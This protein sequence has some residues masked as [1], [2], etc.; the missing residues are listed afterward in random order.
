MPQTATV[1]LESSTGE[2]QVTP[3][4]DE[5]RTTLTLVAASLLAKGDYTLTVTN[6]ESSQTATASVKDR[7]ITSIVLKG[8]TAYTSEDNTKAYIYYDVLDQYNDT[9][10]TS[11][12]INW[13]I[14]GAASNQVNTST[15]KI[16][17]Q[18]S[19]DGKETF[20]Y[21]SKISVTGVE[22]VSGKS[23]SEVIEIGMA[24]A[25]D[26]IEMV[27]FVNDKG[28]KTKIVTSLP[29]DFAK[30]T[31]YLLYKTKD[32]GGNE[33]DAE[34]YDSQKITF[35]VEQPLLVDSGAFEAGRLYTIDGT[36]YASVKVNPG[37]YAERGGDVTF[38][39][40]SNKTGK[41]TPK[42]FAVGE[43][44]LLSSL[45]LMAPSGIIADGDE[46]GIP[47]KALATDG[48]EIKNYE[49]IVRSTNKLNINASEGILEIFQNDDG[50][51]GIKWSDDDKYKA[52]A[53]ENCYSQSGIANSMTR[54]ITLTTIVA[55]GTNVTPLTLTVHDMRRPDS[56]KEVDETRSGL[57]NTAVSGFTLGSA[58]GYA[59]WGVRYYDQYNQVL[60][61]N[62]VKKFFEQAETDKGVAGKN[63]GV[64]IERGSDA[65]DVVGYWNEGIDQSKVVLTNSKAYSIS[66][67]GTESEIEKGGSIDSYYPGTVNAKEKTQFTTKY[68]IVSKTAGSDESKWAT[69]SKVIS[70]TYTVVPLSYM[71]SFEI[72]DT[73]ERYQLITVN[74]GKT[75]GSSIK[76]LSVPVTGATIGDNGEFVES[77]ELK[78]SGLT[79]FKVKGTTKDNV[80]V[81]IPE[82]YVEYVDSDLASANKYAASD[83]ITK[84]YNITAVSA[85]AI[86]WNELYDEDT[87]KATRKPEALKTLR[88]LVSDGNTKQVIA[89]TL[90]ISDAMSGVASFTFNVDNKATNTELKPIINENDKSPLVKD[91][92]G[93]NITNMVNIVYDIT[94]T[95]E[96]DLNSSTNNSLGAFAHMSN[97]LAVNGQ[98]TENIELSGVEIGDKFKVTGTIVGT[99]VTYSVDV[100]VGSDK[101]AHITNK[102]TADD[103]ALRTK[104]GVR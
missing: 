19:A 42:N 90:K 14:G 88:L 16:T 24:Q 34:I 70:A 56:I 84:G 36:E 65:K 33:L 81:E 2:V 64:S 11:A 40:I 87:A 74:S 101:K 61:V 104:L 60:P 23:V 76:D 3:T 12:N 63:Y 67:N 21:G 8:K 71:K 4:W 13:T 30:D 9:V 66:D 72:T 80:V 18:K 100:T 45:E 75:N 29:S 1:K 38:N 27:G 54:N 85:G 62:R 98:S 25:I 53:T 102:G 91:Q 44:K 43:G 103:D 41:K 79:G 94:N 37:Q 49:T 59:D 86:R 58:F 26:E 92:Y 52:D 22:A 6:G 69:A 28:D 35:I 17:I 31:W 20:T 51:A 55:S 99:N 73:A 89:K 15:G 82:G 93:Q 97:S 95:D 77:N 48:T 50:T 7:E 5:G 96:N 32:Q 68:S 47:F 10:K 46:V 78:L 39:A 57:N 83:I